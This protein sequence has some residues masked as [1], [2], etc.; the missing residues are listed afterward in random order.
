MKLTLAEPNDLD[1]DMSEEILKDI[2]FEPAELL[3]DRGLVLLPREIRV[4]PPPWVVRLRVQSIGLLSII[5]E[6]VHLFHL[7]K[8][9]H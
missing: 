9:C 7:K 5:I 2:D 1:F 3:L 6:S 4:I 8:Y